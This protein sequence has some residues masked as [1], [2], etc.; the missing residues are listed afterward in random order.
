[1][2]FFPPFL[3]PSLPS[4]SSPSLPPFP[5]YLIPFFLPLSLPPLS[6]PLPSLS[7]SPLSLPPFFLSL[8]SLSLS[9]LSL[10]PLSPS[11]SLPLLPPL[12]LSLLFISSHKLANAEH[13]LHMK[14]TSFL[15]YRLLDNS[16]MIPT[17]K[18]ICNI[19]SALLGILPRSDD[20]TR[21]L[22]I[23]NYLAVIVVL[24]FL[25]VS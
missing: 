11:S 25:E 23:H 16:L 7:P 14:M 24:L 9:P 13:M 18:C 5:F 15:L 6:L 19:I 12:V 1:M 22:P 4:A 2:S 3:P 10:P 21:S 8:P 20:I 17:I